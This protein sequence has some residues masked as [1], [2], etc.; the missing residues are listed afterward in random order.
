MTKTAYT[1]VRWIPT[2]FPVNNRYEEGCK[3]LNRN[4]RLLEC[5]LCKMNVCYLKDI[6]ILTSWKGEAPLA[7]DMM[8]SLFHMYCS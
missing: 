4:H 5:Q 6:L 7:N 8:C 2:D 3:Y 1:S